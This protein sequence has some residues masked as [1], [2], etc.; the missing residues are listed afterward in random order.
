MSPF[1]IITLGLFAGLASIALADSY[2]FP[3]THGPLEPKPSFYRAI[4][5]AGD[6][7][8]YMAGVG[9]SPNDVDGYEPFTGTVVG[10]MFGYKINDAAGIVGYYDGTAAEGFLAEGG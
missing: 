6:I 9:S 1:A 7:G 5:D 3:A 2:T 10:I 4:D 8:G